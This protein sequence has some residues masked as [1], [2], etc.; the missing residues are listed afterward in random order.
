MMFKSGKTKTEIKKNA[1]DE[2]FRILCLASASVMIVMLLFLFVALFYHS[3]PS[4]KRFGLS[5]LWSNSWDPVR[6]DFGAFPSIFGTLMTTIIAML[7][8][9]P[10]SFVIALFLVE[11]SHPM[12]SKVVGEALDLLAAIPSIIYGMWGLFVFAPF[13]QDYI[14]PFFSKKFQPILDSFASFVSNLLGINFSLPFF[15]GTGMGIGVLTAGVILA[16]MIL[17]FTSAIIRDVFKMVP[18]VVKESAYGMGSTTWEV[19]YNV[20]LKYGMQGILGGVFLGLGRAIGE[21]MAITFVI[22]N[23]QKVSFSMLSPGT[24]IASTLASQFSEA[25]SQPLFK[26]VLLELGLILFLV[27]FFIQIAAQIWLNRIRKSAGGGL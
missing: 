23:A 18:S 22:G 11:L 10:T 19:S 14:Q 20:T 7:I 16:L 25:V 17:P 8:A 15:S 1:A 26:S 21:T 12:V 27:S 9:V 6:Q 2:F 4:I 13:M 3:L 24:T 5:F